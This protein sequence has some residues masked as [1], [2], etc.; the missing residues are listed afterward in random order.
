MSS[1]K[2][3]YR[4]DLSE[5]PLPEILATI[6]RYRVPGIV[7]VSRDGRARRIFVDDGLVVFAASNERDLELTA[8]LLNRGLLDAETAREAEERRARDGLRTGQVLL[9]LGVL[10]PERL[11]TAIT[12]Q[13]REI[14]LGAFEWDTGEAV[15]EAGARRSADLVR[16]DLPIPE[17]IVE[18]IRRTANVK[19]LVQ[20]L[21]SGQTMLE[22]VKGPDLALFSPPEQAFY[23]A[24]DG[25]TALQQLCAQGPGSQAENVRL[26]YAFF[27][28]G[29]LRKARSSPSGAKKIHY[30]TDGGSLGK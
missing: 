28:L 29:L 17:A 12:G 23:R 30:K 11:N 21:G 20:R 16:L 18:G 13:I 10:T 2:F 22:R 24:V 8:F 27:C 4:G 3:E 19:R 14:L 26:L 25:K 1:R 7:S 15:F 9:Q 5:M 6:H